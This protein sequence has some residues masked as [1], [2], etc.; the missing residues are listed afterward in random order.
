MNR[1]LCFAVSL[2]VVACE[3]E[4]PPPVDIDYEIAG[5][6]TRV[7]SWDTATEPGSIKMLIEAQNLGSEGAEVAE[8]YFPPEFHG[9]TH[10]HEL[11]ILYV[12]EGE[13]DHIVNGESHILTPGMVGIVR[14]PDLVVHRVVS[15]GGVR[16]LVIWPLGGEVAGFEASGMRQTAIDTSQ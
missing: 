13:L 3:S 14:E 8:I 11:E 7:F 4:S 16:V 10:P 9:A 1:T 5:Q 2:L 12:L 15:D 6:G